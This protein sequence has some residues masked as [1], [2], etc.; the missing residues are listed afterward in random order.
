MAHVLEM[1]TREFCNPVTFF[2]KV[3]PLY[4]LFHCSCPTRY[5]DILIPEGVTQDW[6]NLSTILEGLLLVYV[7][8]QSVW[9][10]T[11]ETSQYFT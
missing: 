4:R 2:I 6:Q 1:S 9:T 7:A 11:Q 10:I 3:V 5:S 8:T